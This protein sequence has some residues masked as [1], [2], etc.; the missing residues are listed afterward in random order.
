MVSVDPMLHEGGVSMSYGKR[1]EWLN[2]VRP[3]PFLFRNCDDSVGHDGDDRTGAEQQA[4]RSFHTLGKVLA[5][6][7]RGAADGG[8]GFA[9]PRFG[10]EGGSKGP[11]ITPGD[12]EASLLY[13]R[14]AGLV[15]PVMPMA[16]MPALSAQ[17]IA[18]VKEWIN[19]GAPWEDKG[20]PEATAVPG[21]Q[22][23]AT[24]LKHGSYEERPVTADDRQWWSFQKP[25][26]PAVPQVGD[27]R[28]N[29]KPIDA[30][31]K[32]AL[33]EKGLQ[34]APVADRNTLIR[35]AYLDLVGLLPDPAEVNAFVNNPSPQAYERLI[36]KLLAS[37]HYGERWG[38]LWLDVARYADSMGYEF[39]IDQPEAWRYRDYVIKAFNEDKPY[40]RFIVEQLAGDELD[41]PTF[42]SVTATGFI[43]LGPRVGLR[44]EDNP[45]YRYDYLDDIVRT[46]YQGFQGLTVHCARCHDHKFDPITRKDYYKSVAAFNGFVE[47]DHPLV[48]AEEWA[49]YETIRNEVSAKVR[50]IRRQIAEIEKPYREEIFQ[51]ALKQ[52]PADIQEAVNTPEEKRTAGQKLLAQ[53]VISSPA[54]NADQQLGGGRRRLLPVNESDGAARQKLLDQIAELEKQVPPRPPIAYGIR[55]GDFRFLP[56]RSEVPGTGGIDYSKFGF[57]GKFLPGPGDNYTPPPTY[58][59]SNGLGSFADEIKAP[60]IDPGFL[61][62]L[63]EG[64][65]PLV[66]P[67]GNGYVT[68]GRRRALAEFIASEE[69]PLTAQVMVNRIWHQ[70]FGKGIVSTPSNFGKM[71]TKPTNPEL[72]NWLA[73]EFMR[74][75]WSI[76]QMHRLI[77]TLRNL[78]DGV[79]LLPGG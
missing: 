57:T 66:V 51:K 76:K 54:D 19:Q 1:Q 10:A 49:R 43:R 11:A 6:S 55:D 2:H 33:D 9:K 13:Q 68:S 23:N 28:W 16:P 3:V 61:T 39:D 67:P 69:N 5:V 53:Q 32:K 70:H 40:D 52:Y 29:A 22:D 35:R 7:R 17:E 4:R 44:E 77:M 24:L 48:P 62:V 18:T 75:G 78:Q 64:N 41:E 42:D 14:I 71:G 12:A 8:F 72:L 50:P 26:R 45:Q 31:V 21:L 63:S 38:R 74:Q 58:F 20:R 73:T 25:V 37:P 46:T 56:Q 34:P 65:P 30:F 47:Y 59:A 60:V 36:D 15:T 79:D 27:A